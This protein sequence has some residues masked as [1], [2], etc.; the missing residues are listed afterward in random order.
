MSSSIR[1]PRT[2][3][4]PL[5]V[6]GRCPA[7]RSRLRSGRGPRAV[8]VSD[9]SS[10]T[11]APAGRG[12]GA[13]V[14]L[15][16]SIPL[17]DCRCLCLR[18]P[19]S[20]RGFSIFGPPFL[21][22][23][24]S[25]F[26]LLQPLLFPWCLLLLGPPFLLCFSAS[27]SLLSWPQGGSSCLSPLSAPSIIGIAHDCPHYGQWPSFQISCPLTRIFTNRIQHQAL[28]IWG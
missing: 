16:G 23:P 21:I 28:L 4:R 2:G 7:L 6:P 5:E 9:L 27:P 17:S 12:W 11:G 14:W 26:S 15:R 8:N 1:L 19:F 25:F 22:P 24:S 13:P 3:H 18:L 10:V 20:P